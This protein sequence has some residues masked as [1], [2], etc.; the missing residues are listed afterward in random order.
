MKRKVLAVLAAA[1]AITASSGALCL[2]A[3][4][5]NGKPFLHPLFTNNMVLQRNMRFPVWGWAAPG[6][7]VTVEIG[8]RSVTAAAG[9]DG[10]WVA[11]PGK[12]SAGGPY[13][14]RISGGELAQ[15]GRA[16]V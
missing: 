12:F 4:G 3:T 8:G 1:A 5:Y 6:T 9:K 16:H 10:E 7:K 13:T 11:R 15:I 2:A 14:L